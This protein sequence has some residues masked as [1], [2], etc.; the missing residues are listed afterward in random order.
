MG[1]PLPVR[2]LVLEGE[3][4]AL[5]PDGRPQPFQATMSRFGRSKD[6]AAARGQVAL[7]PFFFDLL[8]LREGDG[9]LVA[10][11]YAERA[12]RL[13]TT[14]DRNGCCRAS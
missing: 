7:S 14:V 10:L 2:E 11:P 3:A 6:V 1:A 5:R 13:A 4:I 8:Y 9:P 12:A